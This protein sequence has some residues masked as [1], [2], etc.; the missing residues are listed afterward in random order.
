MIFAMLIPYCR[1]SQIVYAN[2]QDQ[3]IS[4]FLVLLYFFM[5]AL[6]LFWFYKIVLGCLKGLGIIKKKDKKPKVVTNKIE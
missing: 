4:Y 1:D 3:V 2:T 6:N 5:Y